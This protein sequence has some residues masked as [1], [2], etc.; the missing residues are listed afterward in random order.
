MEFGIHFFPSIGPAQKSGEQYFEE[1]LQLV[2]R[3]DELDYRHVRIVEHYFHRYGGYSPNP[4]IFLA[5]ASQRS[6]KARVITGANLPVF[7]SPLKLAGEI[8]MIDAISGGR[9]EI[10]FGRAFLPLEYERFGIDLD[11]SR[12]RFDEGL[13]QTRLL[14]ENENVSAKG[15]FHSFTNT[16][17]LPRPTQ[18]PRPPFWVAAVSSPES[19]AGA[20]RMGHGVMGVPLFGPKMKEMMGIYRDAWKEAGHPGSGKIMLM[21]HMFCWP[22]ETEAHDLAREHINDYIASFA[23]AA[24]DWVSG[25]ASDAYPGYDKLVANLA[26]DNFENTLAR[27]A[28]WVGTPKTIT[29]Q[30]RAFQNDIGDIEIGSFQVNFSEMPVE[31]A[32]QSLENFSRDVMPHFKD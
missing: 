15:Q 8:G 27:G 9:A 6:K 4:L 21:F 26:N 23:D 5:A 20:A 32:E 14:L 16:T 18:K 17:S 10:G 22:D 28:A 1:C 30:I 29:E 19:F 25:T 11:E 13:E 12:P 3:C 2:D 31:L 24:S 7:N